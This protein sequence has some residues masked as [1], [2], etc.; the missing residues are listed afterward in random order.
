MGLFI[1]IDKPLLT[2]EIPKL[3]I[4]HSMLELIINVSDHFSTTTNL[5]WHIMQFKQRLQFV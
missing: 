1:T 4:S 3:H 5:V 2:T